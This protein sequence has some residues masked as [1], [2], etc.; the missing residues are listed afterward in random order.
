MHDDSG[1]DNLLRCDPP[2]PTNRDIYRKIAIALDAAG[3]HSDARLIDSAL[4]NGGDSTTHGPA[5]AAMESGYRATVSAQKATLYL[6]PDDA[7]ASLAYLIPNDVVTVLKQSPAG[8]AYVDY[9]NDSGKHLLRWI[10]I[11]QLMI[12]P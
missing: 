3:A 1:A 12:E 5:P 2:S 9:V 6:I 11:D 8:W 10:K 7:H 4:S